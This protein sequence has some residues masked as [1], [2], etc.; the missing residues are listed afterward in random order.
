MMIWLNGL[1]EARVWHR[2]SVLTASVATTHDIE[3]LEPNAT[4]DDLWH[5]LCTDSIFFKPKVVVIQ[6]PWWL[7]GSLPDAAWTQLSETWSTFPSHH[8]LWVVSTKKVDMRLKGPAALK[9]KS[10]Y[11]EFAWFEEWD[12]AK[13]RQWVMATLDSQL[14]RPISTEAKQVLADHIGTNVGALYPIMDTLNA[15]T[16]SSTCIEVPDV[17]LVLGPKAG[18]LHGLS[19]AVKQR[20][21]VAIAST[22]QDLIRNGE[23]VIKLVATVGSTVELLLFLVSHRGQSHEEIGKKLGRHPYFIKQ[24]MLDLG[25]RYSMAEL[26]TIMTAL[27]ELDVDIKSG[28]IRAQDAP[29][30]L[31]I[32]LTNPVAQAPT[33]R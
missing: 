21:T 1:D 3:R 9:K 31:I 4:L 5:C 15:L 2:L 25:N 11:E 24:T 26:M 13:A 12:G 22:I 7:F 8:Q 23:D 32:L 33:N 27:H 20:N 28:H 17:W 6:N 19:T 29:I 30:R 18:S 10:Q 14:I 16:L